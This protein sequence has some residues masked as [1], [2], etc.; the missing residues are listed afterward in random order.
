MTDRAVVALVGAPGAG[1]TRTGKR[2][3]RTLGVPFVDTDARI[4]A[5]HGVIAEIFA[6]HGE[7]HFRELER[8]AVARALGEPA[9]VALGGGAVLDERT[10]AALA[11]LPVVQLTISAE[12]VE[13]RISN[14]KR[15]L[16][17][18]GVGAWEALVAER[19][20]IYDALSDLTLDTSNRPIDHVAADIVAWLQKEQG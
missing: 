5:D 4:V 16:L 14:G 18:D 11:G 12:A 8:I 19:R 2:V 13:R 1:K 10:R 9:V 20:P 17:K 7:P 6:A 3:A 15:P